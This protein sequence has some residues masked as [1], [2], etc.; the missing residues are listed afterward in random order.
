[1]SKIPEY[2]FIEHPSELKD[3]LLIMHTRSPLIIG[4]VWRFRKYPE[5]IEFIEKHSNKPDFI[6]EAVPGYMIVITNYTPYNI[7][8]DSLVPVDITNANRDLFKDAITDMCSFYLTERILP[9][10]ARFKRYKEDT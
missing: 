2:V 3:K 6:C 8:N 9:N 5:L 10:V 1:M 7:E 4:H